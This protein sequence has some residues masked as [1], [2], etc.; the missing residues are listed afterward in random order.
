[1]LVGR[2][3]SPSVGAPLHVRHR[4]ER[5]I[6]YQ[7]SAR[8][9]IAIV[10]QQLSQNQWLAGEYYSMVDSMLTLFLDHLEGIPVLDKQGAII[11]AGSVC[12]DYFQWVRARSSA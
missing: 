5:T 6:L 8:G 9:F 12:T 3:A 4:P 1:M 2:E 7:L 10:E 11:A